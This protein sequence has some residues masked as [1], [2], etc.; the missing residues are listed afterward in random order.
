MSMP[1]EIV[2]NG[3]AGAGFPWA[4]ASFVMPST[5][6]ASRW[7][8]NLAF[9]RRRAPVRRATCRSCSRDVDE[10]VLRSYQRRQRLIRK[11][12]TLISTRCGPAVRRVLH[13]VHASFTVRL[14]THGLLHRCYVGERFF[15]IGDGA[16][17]ES[18]P[19]S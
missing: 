12:E 11:L 7:K 18:T 19:S 1:S 14:Q 3:A 4:A 5:E 10:D 6:S 9:I 8:G 17:I 13:Q 16:T 2:G 15:K